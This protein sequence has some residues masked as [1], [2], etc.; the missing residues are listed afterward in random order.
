M[1]STEDKVFKIQS[2]KYAFM[3][4]VM[5]GVVTAGCSGSEGDG[6][7]G[8][9]KEDGKVMN[10]ERGLW[11][12]RDEL[13]VAFELVNTIDLSQIEEPVISGIAYLNFDE[14]GNMYFFDRRQMM[15]ISLDKEGNLRWAKGQEGKG[16]GDFE[17]PFGLSV[18]NGKIYVANIQG[19]RLDEFDMDG[20]FIKSYDLPKEIRFASLVGIRENGDVMLSS[21]NWGT[22]GADVWLMQL[23]DS[24]KVKTS[25]RIIETEAEE[26]ERASSRG[27]MAIH[28]DFFTYA[29]STSHG[30]RF[31]NYD[32]TM[33]KEVTRAFDGVMGPG[34]YQT[35]N[36]VSIFSLGNVSTPVFL[37]DGYY[38]VNVRYPTNITDINEY[39]KRASTGETEA[40]VYAEFIDLYNDEGE[41]LYVYDNTEEVEAIGDLSVQDP[42]GYYY[43]SFS[44]D[45]L[46]KKYRVS[47]K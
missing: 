6:N 19:S 23:S 12:D 10:P 43:S 36:S 15:M 42:E 30:H 3:A 5:A 16:P 4:L 13:P 8:I 31:Y 33:T 29:F 38:L 22:I 40:P 2:L 45:L 9:I 41:L 28:E 7:S 44:N 27:D 20:N 21:P 47:V 14:D 26:Y 32:S 1:R 11:Q 37:D 39:A 24:M 34:V 18:H 17:N 25:F 35:D 46:I